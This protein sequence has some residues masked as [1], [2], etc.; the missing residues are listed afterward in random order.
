MTVRLAGP[1][2]GIQTFSYFPNPVFGDTET[3]LQSIDRKRSMNNTRYTYVKRRNQRRR[4]TLRFRMTQAKAFE[5]M[6][7]IRAYQATQVQMNDHLNQVWVGYIITNPNE[8]ESQALAI[9]NPT[10]MFGYGNI[11]IVFE[12][13]KQ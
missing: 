12:G 3:A 8:V 4:V 2:P 5:L 7:F 11:Q 1:Y 6:E 13:V 9:R 10:A